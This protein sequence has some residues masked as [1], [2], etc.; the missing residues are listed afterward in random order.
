MS[1]VVNAIPPL[2]RPDELASA[3]PAAGR[4][5]YKTARCPMSQ[6]FW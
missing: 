5:E 3:T 6:V 2:V 1:V 4:L